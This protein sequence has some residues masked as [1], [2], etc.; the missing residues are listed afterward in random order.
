[1]FMPKFA[2]HAAPF[3]LSQLASRSQQHFQHLRATLNLNLGSGA[4]NAGQQAAGSVGGSAGGIG[5]TNGAAGAGGAKWHAGS[6]AG[7][8][9]YQVRSSFVILLI[10][11]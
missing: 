7:G 2:A 11:G 8:W 3:K 4:S 10:D 1:M 6:R 9:G 5:A